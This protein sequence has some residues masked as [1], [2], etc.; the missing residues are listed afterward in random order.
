MSTDSNE[1]DD[2]EGLHGFIF[3]QLGYLEVYSG[4]ADHHTLGND[5]LLHGDWARTGYA[6]VVKADG[7]SSAPG[8]V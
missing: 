7:K 6:V 8:E 2:N 3:H 5:A 1:S 4:D